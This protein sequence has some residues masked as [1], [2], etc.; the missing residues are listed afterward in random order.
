MCYGRCVLVV[1][2]DENGLGPRLGPLIVTAVTV[3]AADERAAK[4]ALGRPGRAFAA[5]INDSKKLVSY[6]ERALGEAWARVLA[7]SLSMPS[8]SPR[9]LLFGLSLEPEEKLREPCPRDGDHAEQCFSCEGEAFEADADLLGQVRSDLGRLKKRGLELMS[10]RVAVVCTRKLNDAA[11]R[12]TTRFQVDLH[13]MERLVLDARA[14]GA[15]DVIAVCGKV[16]GYNSYSN[17]FGPLGGRL[18]AIVCEGRAKS[19]YS[20]PGLGRMAFV[21]DADAK[22]LVVCLASLVGKYVRDLVTARVVRH[23]K[24]T[25]P[26]LPMVSGY[27]DPVTNRFIADTDHVRR[28]SGFPSDCFER[29]AVPGDEDRET[30]SHDFDI[31]DLAPTSLVDPASRV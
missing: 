20:L 28:A 30:P 11:A 4:V 18:H 7:D 26:H 22:H 17:A 15:E 13:A 14:R 29:R 21:R 5:R 3:A 27:H 19:E 1:G 25:L 9:D 12:G 23:H 16:G 8:K 6:K 10:V 24:R 31:D 2:V